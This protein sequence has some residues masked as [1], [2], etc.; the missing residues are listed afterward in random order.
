MTSYLSRKQRLILKFCY[1]F[2]FY[3]SIFIIKIKIREYDVKNFKYSAILSPKYIESVKNRSN[4][5]IYQQSTRIE[6]G[7]IYYIQ[8]YPEIDEISLLFKAIF[9]SNIHN[10][11]YLLFFFKNRKLII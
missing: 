11:R 3:Y 1:I 2:N 6:P 10:F 9:I 5:K 7:Q 8:P 4:Y